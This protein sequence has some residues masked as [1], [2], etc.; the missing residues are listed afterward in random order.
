VAAGEHGGEDAVHHVL[1]ADDPL[2]H[3]GAK[4][5]HGADEPLEL[6]DVVLG[7]AVGSGHG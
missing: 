2:R 3:L 5:L 4:A 7:D 1:L 6:L